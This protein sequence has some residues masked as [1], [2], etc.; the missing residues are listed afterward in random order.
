M[1]KRTLGILASLVGSAIGAWWVM[2]Q[3]RTRHTPALSPA[4]DHGTI[5][6]DNTPKASDVDA[7]L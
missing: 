5:I 1:S 4:R 7:I 6:F 2:N 3:R